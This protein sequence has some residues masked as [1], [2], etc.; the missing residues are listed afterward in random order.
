MR[1]GFLRHL[2]IGPGEYR[3]RFQPSSLDSSPPRP[4]DSRRGGLD[5]RRRSV[6][7]DAA[8]ASVSS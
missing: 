2:G 5:I 4:A 1:R 3:R 6:A 8:G 7:Q